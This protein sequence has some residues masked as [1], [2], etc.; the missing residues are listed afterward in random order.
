L[1]VNFFQVCKQLLISSHLI[2]EL[3]VLRVFAL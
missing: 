2:L 3:G 1:K